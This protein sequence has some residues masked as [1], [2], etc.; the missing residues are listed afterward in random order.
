MANL[1][2]SIIYI[3]DRSLTWSGTTTSSEQRYYKER[4]NLS[5]IIYKIF[6]PLIPN[7]EDDSPRM[8]YL[9]IRYSMFATNGLK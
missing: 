7:V 3:Y 8:R 4:Y 2:K 1:K 5:S 6:N 9:F